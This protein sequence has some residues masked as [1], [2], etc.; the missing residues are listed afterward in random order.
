MNQEEKMT[1]LPPEAK[2]ISFVPREAIST[3]YGEEITDENA[4]E[5]FSPRTVAAADFSREVT[6]PDVDFG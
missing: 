3:G 2:L 6:D 1:Y 4:F 5:Y